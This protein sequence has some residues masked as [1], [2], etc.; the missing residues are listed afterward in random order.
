MSRGYP[1]GAQSKE[2]RVG[3]V[4]RADV[5]LPRHAFSSP[6]TPLLSTT[7]ELKDALIIQ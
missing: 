3:G 1:P 6:I 2:K 5:T 4:E 7:K